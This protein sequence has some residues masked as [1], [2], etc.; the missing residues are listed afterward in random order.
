M[1]IDPVTAVK[2][3][4]TTAEILGRIFDFGG[5]PRG[6]FQKF[7]RT[8]RPVMS[9]EAS[10]TGLPVYA[11][12]FDDLVV[13]FPDGQFAV[14]RQATSLFAAEEF[15]RDRAQQG[16]SFLVMRCVEG[17]DFESR[18][19]IESGCH[20]ERFEPPPTFFDRAA[21]SVAGVVQREAESRG[22]G[23]EDVVKWGTLG[24]AALFTIKR[25]F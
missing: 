20:F 7:D 13:I 2:I 11:F 23:I 17:T 4:T 6:G 25:L 15:W 10:S 24:T 18:S 19:S 1:P 8:I 16:E 22:I 5:K 3:G 14:V 9:N 21:R 12:W